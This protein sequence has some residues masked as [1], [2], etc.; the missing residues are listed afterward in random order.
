MVYLIGTDVGDTKTRIT[1][2]EL[3]ENHLTILHEVSGETIESDDPDDFV[4]K[5][6]ESSNQLFKETG[7]EVSDVSG[8]GISSMGPLRDR[9]SL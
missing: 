7:V 4:G 9:K 2:G 8:Y 6:I 3:K 1:L 5:I